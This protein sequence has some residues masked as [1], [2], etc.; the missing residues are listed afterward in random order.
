MVVL[1]IVLVAGLTV[2]AS[3][4]NREKNADGLQSCWQAPYLLPALLGLRM[5]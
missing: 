1:I 3:I 2:I 4:A 5:F